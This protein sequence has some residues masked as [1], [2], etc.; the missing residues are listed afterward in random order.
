MLTHNLLKQK[1]NVLF[2][3]ES[4]KLLNVKLDC[5]LYHWR[6]TSKLTLAAAKVASR[7]RETVFVGKEGVII[8][9]V[10]V[11]RVLRSNKDVL[12]R[13]TQT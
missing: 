11:R 5:I 10:I 3:Y 13:H 8:S 1:S 6:L 9:T 7:S 4:N 12:L 2:S